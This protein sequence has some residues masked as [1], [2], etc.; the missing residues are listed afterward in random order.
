MRG[1]LGA[2][3]TPAS[4]ASCS[5]APVGA[6]N[7]TL[8]P[9]RTHIFRNPLPYPLGLKLQGDVLDA[10]FRARESGGGSQDM[11]FMLGEWR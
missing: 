7:A 1:L 5:G 10:R 8:P 6:N 3:P 9:V 2:A 11:L 4:G